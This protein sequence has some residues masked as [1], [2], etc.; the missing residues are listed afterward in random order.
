[1]CPGDKQQLEATT[2]ND[3]RQPRGMSEGGENRQYS[4]FERGDEFLGHLS[5]FLSLDFT[6]EP[7]ETENETEIALLIKL[8]HIVGP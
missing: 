1:M 8:S 3:C 6:T 7:T 2:A 4:R 5:K